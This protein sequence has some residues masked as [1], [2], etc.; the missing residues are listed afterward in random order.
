MSKRVRSRRSPYLRYCDCY[1][2]SRIELKTDTAN[3]SWVFGGTVFD[4]A[5]PR[6]EPQT[7]CSRKTTR[8]RSTKWLVLILCF[9]CTKSNS[10]SQKQS[11]YSDISNNIPTFNPR[12]A[13]DARV[14][15]GAN[16]SLRSDRTRL[17]RKSL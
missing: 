6:F 9:L 14:S 13:W 16:W 11:W 12:I 7:S 2:N 4:L 15:F 8:C 3:A 10:N 17:S 1:S 5:G